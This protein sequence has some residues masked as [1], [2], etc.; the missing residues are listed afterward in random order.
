DAGQATAVRVD[1][2]MRDSSGRFL[3][4]PVVLRVVAVI[5]ETV[6]KGANGH[7]PVAAVKMVINQTGG[8]QGAMGH[9]PIVVVNDC[10]VVPGADEL[11]C[12]LPGVAREYVYRLGLRQTVA[13]G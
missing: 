4:D 3:P 1:Q 7:Q 9:V 13:L 8:A 10:M 12:I 11:A 6:H 2:I 5:G